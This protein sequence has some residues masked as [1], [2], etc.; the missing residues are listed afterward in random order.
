MRYL[1]KRIEKILLV[2]FF[3]LQAMFVQAQSNIHTGDITVTT[4]AA[5]DA[6]RTTLAGKTIINGNLTIGYTSGSSRSDITDLSPLS[7]MTHITG[8]VWIQQNGQLV[9]LNALTHL[10]T[11]GGYLIIGNNTELQSLGDFSALETIGGYLSISNNDNLE[12]LSNSNLSKLKSIGGDLSISNHDNLVTLGEFLSLKSIGGRLSIQSNNVLINLGRLLVL[13][14]IGKTN[15]TSIVVEENPNLFAC[16]DLSDFLPTQRHPATGSISINNNATGCNLP[17][18]GTDAEKVSALRVVCE[19]LAFTSQSEINAFDFSTANLKR[20]TIGPSSGNDAITDISALSE[21]TTLARLLITDNQK[22]KFINDPMDNTNNGLVNLATIS[23]G[24]LIQ[25]NPLLVNLNGFPLLTKV[26]DL[27]VLNNSRLQNIDGLSALSLINGHVAVQDNSRLQNIDGISALTRIGRGVDIWNNDNLQTICNF[28]ALTSIGKSLYIWNNNILETIGNFP[29]LKSIRGDVRII[30]NDALETIGDFSALTSI[31]GYVYIQSNDNLQSLG[32]LSTLKS[33]GRYLSIGNT[34]LQS[35]GDFSALTS[36]GEY[37][38]IGNNDSLET[39][40]NFSA[41]TSIRGYLRIYVNPTLETI[42]NFSALTSIEGYL[43]ID[44]STNLQ[45]LDGFSA[46]KSVGGYLSINR[47]INL[48]SLDGL[49]ALKSIGGYLSIE[50]NRNLQSFSGFSAL[51]SIGGYLRIN[52]NGAL[53]TI[54]GFSALTS[55]GEHLNIKNNTNLQSLGIFPVLTSIGRGTA[56]VPLE[57]NVSNA[58]IV[59]QENTNLLDCCN[60]IDFLSGEAHAVSGRIIINHNSDGCNFARSGTDA[61]KSNAFKATCGTT[62]LTTQSEL[63]TFTTNRFPARNIVI[64]PSSGDDAI[65]NIN[66]LRSQIRVLFSLTIQDNEKLQFI[67]DPTNNTTNGVRSLT[68]ISDSL[69]IKNN[70]LLTNLN[71]FKKL[72]TVGNISVR[73]NASLVSLGNFPDLTQIRGFFDVQNNENLLSLGNLPLLESIGKGSV[74][75]PSENGIVENV[76]IVVEGNTSLSK[77]CAIDPFVAGGENAITNET[78]KLFFNNNADGCNTQAEINCTPFLLILPNTDISSTARETQVN[79]IS[80]TRWQLRKPNT[81]AGWINRLKILRERV[82]NVIGSNDEIVTILHDANNTTQKR[83]ATLT[84]SAVDMDDV[85]LPTPTATTIDLTQVGIAR[86]LAIA[87]SANLTLRFEGGLREIAITSNSNWRATTS[88]PLVHSLIFTPRTGSFFSP[89]FGTPISATPSGGI[90]TLDG[91]RNGSLGIMYLENRT[92]DTQSVEITLSALDGSNV[93]NSNP[94]PITITLTQAV[95][96]PILRI[97]SSPR[98][99]TTDNLLYTINTSPSRKTRPINIRLRGSASAWV[100]STTDT[101]VSFSPTTGG[102]D[103][104]LVLTIGANPTPERRTATIT[105]TPTGGTGDPETKTLTIKQLAAG[106]TLT[107]ANTDSRTLDPTGGTENIAI[108]S[109]SNWRATTST[110]LAT[111]TSLTF[112]PGTGAPTSAT[113]SGGSITLN[114]VGSGTLTINYLENKTNN[115]QRGVITLSALDGSSN[116]LIRN[117]RPINLTLVQI[118]SPPTLVI[119]SDATLSTNDSLNYTAD[120]ASIGLTLTLNV[121]VGGNADGW[122]AGETTDTDNIVSL[123]NNPFTGVDGETLAITI[124][125]NPT[126]EIRTATI[127]F[128]STGGTGD[129]A[130]QTLTITQAAGPRTIAI[131]GANSQ[132]TLTSSGGTEDVTITSNSEWRVTTSDV[133]VTSLIFTPV[134]G[135][136]VSATPSGGNITLDATGDGTLAVAYS[137]N[138]TPTERTGTLT[139]SARNGSNVLLTP[140]PVTTTLTQAAA[141]RAIAFSSSNL[142]ADVA[143]GTK[144]VTITSNSDWRVTTSDVLVTSLTFTPTTGNNTTATPSGGSITLDATGDGTLV[145]AYSANDTIVERTGTLTLSAKNGSTVLTTNPS[146]VTTT[147]TQAARAI[148]FSSSNLTADVAAGTKDVTITSN[149]DW[150]VTTSDVLVTSLTF[151]PVSGSTVSATPSRG[152]ITLDATGNGTLAVAYSENATPAERTGTLTLSAKNGST[153]LTTNPSPVTTTLTQ[154]AAARAIAFSSNSLSADAAAGTKDVTITSN[155]DWRVITSDVLVTSLTFTPTTGNNT[156]ATP[157]GGSITLDATG[158]GTLVV[159]YSANDTIVERTGTLTLSA[160]NGSTVLTTNPSP[161]TTTLTQA[162]AARA[163]AFS[164]SSL[165]ADTAAGTKDVTITSNSDW[166]VTTSDVLVT[167]LTFTPVSGSPT[168]INSSGD[169]ITLNAT[170]DGTLA[171]AYSENATPTERTGTLTLS[172]KNGSNVLTT[173]P[174]PVT[175]TLTQAAAA[176][177]I[178]FS[179]SSLS[180]DAAAGTKDVT[181]T[182]NSDWRVTTSD[183]LVTS[184]TFTPVSGSLTSINSSGSNITLNATGDGTLVVAY[185]ENVTPTERTGTLTL[186]AKNGSTVLTTPSPVTATLTQAAAARAIAFSSNSLSADVAAGTKDVTITSNSDWRVTTSDTLVTSLTFTPVSGS[187]TSATPSGGSITLD[188][189]GNG[190]LAVAYSANGTIVERRGTLT[191]SALDGSANVLTTN[192]TPITITLTQEAA[193]VPTLTLTATGIVPSSGSEENYTYDTDASQ[194]ILNVGFAIENATGWSFSTTANFVTSNPA[195]GGNDDDAVL[196]ITKNTTSSQRTGTIVFTTTGNTGEAATQTLVITQLVATQTLPTLALAGTGVTAPSGEATNYTADAPSTSSTLNVVV[197]IEN[198]TGWRATETTDTDNIVSLANDPFTGVDGENLAITIVA[199]MTSSQRTGTLT[200]TSTGGDVDITQTLIITQ[201]AAARTLAFSSS[202]LSADAAAGTKD[203]T[204]TSNSDWRVTTSDDLVTS[205]TFTPTTGN[206]TTATPS[207]GSITLDA[208]G[209]GTLVVAYSENGTIV[210]RTGTLTL[211]AKNGVDVLTTNPT[212]VT[213]TLTQAAA[214]RAIAFSSSSFSADAAAGTK[215]VTITSNSDWR[216]T[217]SDVLISSLTF[218]PTTGNNTIAMPING[219][220]TLDGEGNGTLTVAYLENGTPAERTGTLTLSAKNGSTVLTTNPSPVTTTLT[221]AAAARAIAFSSNSLSADAAAGTKDVTIASNSDWQVTTSDVLVTSLTFTSVSG[222]AVSATPSGDS[223][224]LDAT[225]DGTL[226]VAYSTNATTAERTATLTLSAK[227]GSTVLTTNPSPVTT[228]LTQAAAARAIAFSSSGLSAD[229]AAG[230][231]DVTITSNSDWRVT[232]SDVLVTSL[233]FTPVLGSSVSATPSGGSITLDATGNGTLAVAYSANGTIVERTGTLT[234]SALDGSANVLTTNPT[235]IT[236]TL[237][238]EAAPATTLTLTATGVTAPSGSEENYTYDTDASQTTL[239]VGFAI[240]NATGWSFSTTANFVTSNPAM[241]GNDDDAVLTITKNTTSSQRTGTIV[242]TTTGNTG[243]AATQTLVITQL[244]A[245]QTLPTLALAGTGVTALSGEAT[246]YTADAP[247][248]SSTLN[249]VVS[250]ENA[251]GW[252]A[253]ETTDTDNIVSLAND[254]VIGGNGETLVITIA[255]NMTSSQRTGTLT[256]TSTGGDVDITQTLI[257]TQAAAAGAIAFSSSSLSADA[258]AGTKDVT[259]TSNS[260]WR[261]T[262]S[263]DLVTSLT[264][265]PASGSSVSATPSGGSTTLDATG[266]STTLDATGDGTLVVAYSENATTAERIGTLTLSALDG[267]ANVLTTNPSPVTTTLTQ[268]AAA[269]SIAFSSSSLSADT[270]AGTKDVTI[271][272]NSDWQV[273]T[274]DVLVTSLTFT[275]VSGSA[276]SATPSGDSITLDATGD[277]T[278][279][280]A[281]S[282]NATTAERTAT[283]TLS[284]KNGS[285]V[286][287]TNPSPVTTTLTQAAAARSIAF[288]SSSL[289]ADTAAGTKDVTITSN[290]DWRVTTSDVLVTSLTFTP[291][292]GSSVSATPSGGSITLDATGSGTLA[293][294]YSANGTIVERTG[295][296]TLSAKNGSTVL[297]TNPSP[298]TTTLTQDAAARAIAFSSNSL[299]EDAA[300]GTKDVTITSNSDWRVTTSDVLVTSLTFTP[301]SGSSVSATPSG[302]SITLDATGNGTLAVAYSANGTIVERRGTL[303]LSAKNG[304]NVLL[305]PTPITITLTQEAAPAT[306][307]TLTATGVTAPSGSEENYTADADAAGKML[308]VDVD[309]E[310]AIGWA[311]STTDAFVTSAPTTGGNDDNAVLTIASNPTTAERTATIIFTSTGGTGTATQTLVITQAAAAKIMLTSHTEDDSI[312]IAHDNTDPITIDFTLEGSA[313]GWTDTIIYM[314]DTTNFITI[315]TLKDDTISITITPSVNTS[316]EPRTATITLITTG[317]EGTPD[318]V[319]LTIT[320]GVAPKIMLTSHTEDDSIAIAHDNTDPITIDFTLEGSATG[321]TD[322]IIYIP[323][324]TNFITMDTLKDDTISITITPSVNTSAEP[325]TATITLITTGHEGTPDSVSLTITQGARADTTTLPP[326]DT[327]TTLYSYTRVDFSLYPNPTKGTLTIEGVTG[328]LQMYIY[329]LVG[330][331]VMTYSLTPSKKTIDVSDLPSGMYVVT[332]QGEDKTWKEI[333]MKK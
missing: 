2:T 231:K 46:L 39:L 76:A 69:I 238:Q 318:S 253:T 52:S 101:F 14:S 159:A 147:L 305:T 262:T 310:N 137:A 211:S 95:G 286:L 18:S 300:A 246:N 218:T 240:E 129:A 296:L 15:D 267:S 212:P 151:T 198:A 239:N 86:T 283:L 17:E 184:L 64:G 249:V 41:L 160:K 219:N 223:I 83:T 109:N 229:T 292:S 185:S 111:I 319:S 290:S 136:A 130:T 282:T 98:L 251:T 294:A 207:G 31:G 44:R 182:S 313:T 297:T 170:G 197:A 279:A 85:V 168:S 34:N 195:M 118:V 203:V 252:R 322:T 63:N 244:V 43:S 74:F 225:G 60:I 6:L 75:V 289:S 169:N 22:L 188:A 166:R 315:D 78:A 201:A 331:E 110:D 20:I 227:N 47:S 40:G 161:V 84:L 7:N 141:A 268:A 144:D 302:G 293:V 276:V 23:G 37:I 183:V 9:N 48:Q 176:R 329:D 26:G 3:A 180:A 213:T 278:L 158:D 323:D 103:V 25:N 228:T 106:R 97:T 308:T 13:T 29:A 65:T 179:S 163:I 124:A 175:T 220:I 301:V 174:T 299:S 186:S 187:A 8:D 284:A 71:G 67:D 321:W 91:E 89:R 93:L 38:L 146:P 33:I 77:C 140:T 275:P 80:N 205:L 148:A 154:A 72:A 27:S 115:T 325:R 245:T 177:A 62:T 50:S 45:S 233:T 192:P 53:K 259:I 234:L 117:P 12:T 96:P 222:S 73:D 274:S 116:V 108:I 309:L 193:P 216:V 121:A 232:T 107:I 126:P 153:V 57:G 271:T 261:V 266:G 314:P 55:I 32:D 254:P 36:I 312:A 88:S 272:S 61:A 87:N 189:T 68:R 24:L 128:T 119:S 125:P 298:V 304:S 214:A 11:I 102:D 30:G 139:L 105:F 332:L 248:T 181:I 241:G 104:D 217:T 316:A 172:A 99:S 167:S 285:T 162:A 287:T 16:C 5:V 113:P 209:D 122:K 311:F 210:E 265:T 123:P 150:R 260:D 100:A 152:N 21:L 66:R 58:S 191:L 156:T 54:D 142:T 164:S 171:V 269:R 326:K 221:Q 143:A 236:I 226:A 273:T 133:L 208:T 206:N 49:S 90:I 173:N 204:I 28:S 70:P 324:T 317:H 257:I 280:V 224:T 256:F 155:S 178:A 247:S 127:T 59:I 328:Y 250:I 120:A 42:G 51:T 327:T 82:S 258:A 134:S 165:S 243:E 215:D 320:Q 306:T 307:L 196:T 79:I 194:T 264:F 114:G 263:D 200:F 281:Y 81:G 149:S 333:L 242:F 19:R 157:S 230:T 202:S 145:V 138:A 35:L 4:Q 255:S 10:Q 288:S 135:S 112:T 295:T 56:V 330:R 190:T 131:T 291:V 303:T 92:N 237:T 1:L 132:P 235:P 199:N 270:A 277:G 94:T